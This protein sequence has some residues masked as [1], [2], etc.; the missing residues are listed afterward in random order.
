MVADGKLK[1]EDPIAFSKDEL[2]PDRMHS[3]IRDRNPKGG[4]MPLQEM[5]KAAISESDGT[6]ADV[7]QRVAGGANGVQAHI[8]S[9]G[10]SDMKVRYTHKEFANTWERQYEN[11]TTPRA[12]VQLL[13]ALWS[14]KQRR[15]RAAI[16]RNCF[17]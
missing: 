7:L 2:V 17:C 12:A 14:Q 6:A 11:S 15:L 1:L 10:I 16:R 5:I 9:F 3:P 4:E 8:D 13:N